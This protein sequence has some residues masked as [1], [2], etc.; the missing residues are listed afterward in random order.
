M[1]RNKEY[2]NLFVV[3]HPLIQHKLSIMRDEN[4]CNKDFR[5]LLKEITWLLGYEA[6]A[7]LE[8]CT[9]PVK[10]PLETYKDAPFLAE[11]KP[12]IIPILRAGLFMAEGMLSLL[13][14]ARI[15]HIGMYRDEK[16]KKPV[17]YFVKI[18]KYNSEKIF[19]VDPMFA[20]GNSAV[21]AV[22]I[23]AKR[24]IDVNNVIF[25]ALV[26]TMDAVKTF[27]KKYPQIPI[28]IA[29][30][31]RELNNNAYILPGLGDAG[32]RLFGTEEIQE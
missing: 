32:D 27:C 26:G 10:T 17:E 30:I 18:P 20:T 23:L 4:T 3:N 29:A 31:D 15:G 25:V 12:F 5:T 22:D 9:R 21:D 13:P 24:G 8:L 19:L 28:Y 11:E 2:P 14:C 6:T 7:N 1:Y 16:T